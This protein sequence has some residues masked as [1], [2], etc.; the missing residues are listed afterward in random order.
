MGGTRIAGLERSASPGQLLDR[1]VSHEARDGS[2]VAENAVHKLTGNMNI[3][4][5]VLSIG[6][7]NSVGTGEEG[8]KVT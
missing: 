2:F 1:A 3:P 6:G 5:W 8:R 7:W 4:T